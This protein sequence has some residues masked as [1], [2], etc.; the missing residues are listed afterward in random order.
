M[1]IQLQ[2]FNHT[3]FVTIASVRDISVTYACKYQ[4][5]ELL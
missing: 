5:K 3:K 4:L 1:Q 2:Y